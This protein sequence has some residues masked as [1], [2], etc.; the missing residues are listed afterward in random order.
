MTT[1]SDTH[2]R[3]RL[4]SKLSEEESLL[5]AAGREGMMEDT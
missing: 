1:T 3:P 2:E 4:D 5:V